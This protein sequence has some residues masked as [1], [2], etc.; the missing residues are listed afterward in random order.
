MRRLPVLF[1]LAAA[2]LSPLRAAEG[3]PLRITRAAGPITVDGDLSDPGWKNALRFDTWYETNPGDNVEPKVKTVGWL[4]YDD[5]FLYAAIESFDPKP[6]EI[7]AQLGDHDG[8]NGSSDDFGGVI[9]DARNDGKTAVEFFANAAGT[10]Y[11]ATMDDTAGNEDPSPDFFWDSATKI[12][13]RGWILELR[14]PFS[15]LRYEKRDPQTWGIILYR[16]MPRDRRYQIFTHVLP[17]GSNCFVCSF[18]KVAGF[19]G[20]PSG[21]HLIAAPYI[22]AREVG[23]RREGFG[24]GLRNRPARGDGGVDVKWTPNEH[25]AIDATLNPDFS[26]VESDVAAIATNERFAIFFPEKRPFFLERIDLFSTPIQ[27]VYTRSITSPRFGAR[28]SGNFGKS[29]YTLLVAQDR[30]GGSVIIPSPLGSDFANQD[31]NSTVAI[32]RMRH[33]FGNN[34]FVSFLGTTRESEGGAHNRVFGPDFQWRPNDRTTVTGQFLLSNT[35]TPNR[36]A[37]AAEWDGRKL[38][39]HAADLWWAYSNPKVDMWVEGKDLGDDFRADNGFVP[40]V[41]YRSTYGEVGYTTRP[42]GF[43]NRIRSFA[44]SEYDSMQDGSMLYRLFSAGFGADGKFRSFSRWRYSLEAVRNGDSIFDRHRIY[45]TEQFAVSRRVPQ[46]SIDGW[47]G[48]EV[49]FANNRLG[50]G[51][52]VTVTGSLRL[53][54]RF[55]VSLT[56]G[57]RWLRV[58]ADNGESGRLFTSQVERVRAQYMFSPQMFVRAIV[59]NQRTNRNRDLYS[60][61]VGQHSGSLATQFLFAYKLNWQSVLYLGY[62]DIRDVT[63][64]NADFDLGTRQLFLKMSYAFQR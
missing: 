6:S 3:P 19:E 15:S 8:I 4:T 39:S 46:V 61:P 45:Y 56:N 57:V 50:K 40:Q 17:R 16:N 44:F 33:D 21:G 7:R 11:D 2:S 55:Q 47:A 43:F 24:S 62:G 32:G 20:L 64:G 38:A 31:F 18:N 54:P 53:T 10:Q 25:T 12:T 63:G 29:S 60:F 49:D 23:E 27:A 51:A 26:Q 42:K 30:G 35:R 48:D 58:R 36:P 52:N 13:D 22:T 28:G 5:Q 41:G 59:Q 14:I 34:S 37:E 9:V 1:A